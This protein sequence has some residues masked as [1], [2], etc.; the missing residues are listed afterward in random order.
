MHAVAFSLPVL[1]GRTD[2]E[3]AALASCWV[4]ARREA[5]HDARRRAG[6]TREA[7]WLQSTASGDLAVVH[8]EADDLERAATVLGSSPDPFDRW[9]REHVLLVHG[10]DLGKGFP[11]PELVLDFDVED[12]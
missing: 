10:I 4:G 5:H 9:F 1:P 6:I 8:L 7:V 3:R 2:V 12:V 11:T